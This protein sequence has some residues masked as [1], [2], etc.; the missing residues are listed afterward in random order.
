MSEF[1]KL[2][3]YYVKD[4]TARNYIA[5]AINDIDDINH[6]FSNLY[7]ENINEM[8]NI[9]KVN[10]GEIIR[11]LG[12]YANNDGGDANYKIREKEENETI[13]NKTTFQLTNFNNLVAELVND[14][15]I[16]N[17]LKLGANPVNNFDNTEILQFALDNYNTIYLPSGTY[18]TSESLKFKN[19]HQTLTGEQR[20]LSKILNTSTDIIDTNGKFYLTISNIGLVSD[21]HSGGKSAIT[22]TGSRCARCNFEK[23][24]IYDI[25]YGIN[26]GSGYSDGLVIF[27]IKFETVDYCINLIHSEGATIKQLVAEPF[28][29]N[30]I[31]LYQSNACEVAN[32]IAN[33]S[34][35]SMSTS[36]KILFLIYGS[37]IQSGQ[38]AGCDVHIHDIHAEFIHSI[39]FIAQPNTTLEN[40]YIYNKNIATNNHLIY[41]GKAGNLAPNNLTLK[42][43][44][45]DN[46]D[47]GSNYDIFVHSGGQLILVDVYPVNVAVG[48]IWGI[49]SEGWNPTIR[50]NDGSTFNTQYHLKYTIYEV[51]NGGRL[52]IRDVNTP[53]LDFAGGKVFN[54]TNFANGDLW[55]H[56]GGNVIFSKY[57]GSTWVDISTI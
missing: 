43:I 32:C 49:E 26:L 46:V 28:V 34:E 13:N 44:Y 23:L 24:Y 29:K 27:D 53:S 40:I 57:N 31:R 11:T 36:D 7:V 6:K 52:V 16:I 42:N 3:G 54:R 30:F 17:V 12:F 33:G 45:K 51:A 35:A 4:A 15:T 20:Y 37:T 10:S 41:L 14:Q 18:I 21:N 55:I 38:I 48:K 19:N 5:N 22:N 8:K 50:P 1:S 2:N 9:E 47:I 56:T 25:G 39:G